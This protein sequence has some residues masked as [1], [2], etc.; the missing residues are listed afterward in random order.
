VIV[1]KVTEAELIETHATDMSQ[2]VRGLLEG[3]IRF[4]R[5][6][7]R[8]QHEKAVA[9]CGFAAKFIEDFLTDEWAD[10]LGGI[11]AFRFR[12]LKASLAEVL[13]GRA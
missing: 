1:A 3:A 10:G 7:M 6:D 12:R 4:A 2:H 5:D 13:A 11:A 9:A 8:G